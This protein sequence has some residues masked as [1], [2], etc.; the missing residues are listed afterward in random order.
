MARK[1]VSSKRSE[2]TEASRTSTACSACCSSP[3]QPSCV[4]PLPLTHLV[5]HTHH[6][7]AG[8]NAREGEPTLLVHR[9][10]AQLPLAAAQRHTH[11]TA[12]TATHHLSGDTLRHR[13]QHQSRRVLLTTHHDRRARE[14]DARHARGS[15]NGLHGDLEATGRKLRGRRGKGLREDRTAPA[16]PPRRPRRLPAAPAR[17]SGAAVPPA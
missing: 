2:V 12:S 8:Q 10:R 7:F 11:V 13:L 17:C 15:G 3:K 4:S 9:R 14:H 5:A 6:I 16:S 1:P